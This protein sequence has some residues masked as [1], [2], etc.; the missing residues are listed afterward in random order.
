MNLYSNSACTSHPIGCCIFRSRMITF[1]PWPDHLR[2]ELIELISLILNRDSHC[3]LFRPIVVDGIRIYGLVV[4]NFTDEAHVSFVTASSFVGKHLMGLTGFVLTWT[5]L[6]STVSSWI[7]AKL[8]PV[9]G[10]PETTESNQTK[11]RRTLVT[12]LWARYC[13]FT[14]ALVRS[15][16]N[17]LTQWHSRRTTAD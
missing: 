6:N 15:N 4:S 12:R 14:G 11:H 8:V 3:C 10:M 7:P 1:K 9:V 17:K 16:A 5:E 13:R 2:G